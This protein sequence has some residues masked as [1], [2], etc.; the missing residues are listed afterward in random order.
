M[1]KTIN[2]FAM[3]M[4]VYFHNHKEDFKICFDLFCNNE[5]DGFLVAKHEYHNM[6]VREISHF[7]EDFSMDKLNLI[8]N[9]V[10]DDSDVKFN[11]SRKYFYVDK[12]GI[13]H[14]TD[15]KEYDSYEDK[16][17]LMTMK[18]FINRPFVAKVLK[19]S[20][21]L[22]DETIQLFNDI[23]SRKIKIKY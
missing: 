9:G 7:F 3:E 10:D 19:N 15:K 2:E 23:Y 16:I 8:L 18:Q 20:S 21:N 13:L 1:E 14:S 6:N 11:S 22:S 17:N 12:A 4:M 5:F